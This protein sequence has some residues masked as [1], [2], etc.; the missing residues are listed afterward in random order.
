[1]EASFI[2]PAGMEA[3]FIFFSTGSNFRKLALQILNLVEI[4]RP[5]AVSREP[6][7]KPKA[8]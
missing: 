8:D 3:E 5:L 1:M 6:Q 7:P 2:F 4:N